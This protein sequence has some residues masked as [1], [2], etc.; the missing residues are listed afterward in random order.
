M[1]K[2]ELPSSTNNKRTYLDVLLTSREYAC[3]ARTTNTSKRAASLM[4][5]PTE[6]ATEHLENTT[7]NDNEVAA[8]RSDEQDGDG[9]EGSTSSI[10][11][12]KRVILD[13][14]RQDDSPSTL[15]LRQKY[16]TGIDGKDARI[17]QLR[18]ALE[19]EETSK[20][21]FEN[22]IA[23]EARVID[24][25][26][27]DVFF[28]PI[29]SRR[30]GMR[31][32]A[33]SE[34]RS[35][36]DEPSKFQEA[37]QAPDDENESDG[38]STS[39]AKQKRAERRALR[40]KHRREK[41]E[42]DTK[43]LD[44]VIAAANHNENKGSNFSDD[45]DD[46]SDDDDNNSSITSKSN[47][48]ASSGSSF[49]SS[50]SSSR[51]SDD[52][53]NDNCS[54]MKKK[55][56]RKKEKERERITIH[57]RCM[58]KDEK[59]RAWHKALEEERKIITSSDKERALQAQRRADRYQAKLLQRLKEKQKQKQ[60]RYLKRHR[61]AVKLTR[62]L[63]TTLKD[64]GIIA[65]KTNID[66]EKRRKH[67]QHWITK[68]RRAFDQYPQTASIFGRF[69]G[70]G[71][72]TKPKDDET[73]LAVFNVIVNF[74]DPLTTK[75]MMHHYPDGIKILRDL[76]NLCYADNDEIGDELKREFETMRIGATET[77]SNFIIRIK[78]KAN[79]ARHYL[80]LI[81]EDEVYKKVLRGI[82]RT[83]K[84]YGGLI[85][86]QEGL[87]RKGRTLRYLEKKMS[88]FDRERNLASPNK[89][90][91]AA[92]T[93]SQPSRLGRFQTLTTDSGK[94]NQFKSYCNHCGFFGHREQD[95]KGKQQGR[96]KATDEEKKQ[97]KKYCEICRKPGL[98]ETADHDKT[99]EK[100]ARHPKSILKK[101]VMIDDPDKELG[102]SA[103][104]QESPAGFFRRITSS[105]TS[106]IRTMQQVGSQAVGQM[107]RIVIS[108]FAFLTTEERAAYVSQQHRLP[109]DLPNWLFDSG[110]TAHMTPH[111]EDL[112]R[113]TPCDVII[114]LADGSEVR[115]KHAGECAIDME[116]DDGIKRKLRMGRVLYV[117]GLDRRLLSVPF[118]CQT[119]GNTMNFSADDIEMTFSGYI[120]KTFPAII[121]NRHYANAAVIRS[122]RPQDRLEHTEQKRTIRAVD[123]D[124]LHLR[125]GHRGT[126]AIL[127]ASKH[128]I[129]RDVIAVAGADPFCTSCRI[130][131]QPRASRSKEPMPIP[132]KPLDWVS[133]DIE[134]NPA[135]SKLIV[136]DYYPNIL[137]G[138]DV[139]SRKT[140]LIGLKGETSAD[141]IR[142]LKQ[143]I[144]QNGKMK[145]IRSDAGTNFLSDKVD[146]WLTEN[147]IQYDAS[148]PEGQNTNGFT[149]RHWQTIS[150]MARKM[151]VHARLSNDFVYHAL[152][153]ASAIHNALPIKNLINP[154]GVPTSPDFLF[155]GRKPKISQFRIFG[156]PVVFKKHKQ[157]KWQQQ[158][159]RGIFIGLPRRQSGWLL[160]VPQGG[161]RE[162]HVSKDVTFDES[163]VTAQ[164]CP[165]LPFQ[166]AIPLRTGRTVRTADDEA[167]WNDVEFEHTGDITS[168]YGRVDPES[169][170][171]DTSSTSADED[172]ILLE[173]AD[174]NLAETILPS[175]GEG[176]DSVPIE[177]DSKIITSASSPVDQAISN[178]DDDEA[179]YVQL[180]R[181]YGSDKT[182]QPS[183][184]DLFKNSVDK[185]MSARE[186]HTIREEVFNTVTK[187]RVDSLSGA[188]DD[189]SLYTPEPLSVSQVLKLTGA[190]R[191]R[192]LAAT[193]SEFNSVIHNKTFDLDGV[194]R[195]DEKVIP[196]KVVYKAKIRSDG[197]LEKLKARI[198]VRG[199]IHKRQSTIPE[200]PWVPL[201]SFRT[202]RRF[203]ADAVKNKR[204]L[205]Q[206]DYVSAFCQ[207]NMRGRVFVRLPDCLAEHF[208]N[209]QEYFNR[210]LLLKRG[211]YG[212][213]LAGKFWDDDMRVWLRQF[214][215]M[216]STADP[217]ILIKRTKSGWIKLMS[218]V[219]DQLYFGS[220]DYMEEEF[221]KALAKRFKIELKGKAHWFLSTR[222]TW[223]SDG[224]VIDQARYCSN[225][226][227]RYQPEGCQ[228]GRSPDRHTPLP[229]GTQMSTT[230]CAN[231][232]DGK[233]EVEKRFGKLD[234]RSCI[235]SLIYLAAGTR[236]D[237]LYAVTKLAKY[238]TNPGVRHFECLYH[239]LGYLN[240]TKNFGIRYYD[241]YEKAPV[242][243]LYKSD[244]LNID[245]T[246][247]DV[248]TTITFT[249]ASFQDQVDDGRSSGS[250]C[251]FCRGGLVD[252]G[253][254]V[255][256]PVAM[257]TGEAEYMS[258]ATGAMG[259][260][261]MRMLE[262]DLE[263]LG[264]SEYSVLSDDMQPPAVILIDN[265]A[266]KAMA[267]CER[268][269]KMTRH[270]VR[271]YHYVRQG[272]ARGDHVIKWISGENQCADIGTK[273]Q[274]KDDYE[275]CIKKMF[276]PVDLD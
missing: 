144:A 204:Q 263:N 243:K 50:T 126:N 113:I 98:H 68:L 186:I 73:N 121:H 69:D 105:I 38:D 173:A 191:D 142:G 15:N 47:E 89:R 178:D 51:S 226:L 254:F 77:G 102:L 221:E 225:L 161:C 28:D 76:I 91:F 154:V 265:T 85:M 202:L 3:M 148:P 257:S 118:F 17:R 209:A 253:C 207:G 216:P 251:I 266:A 100:S 109:K 24:T 193:K 10:D 213:T 20:A 245:H 181:E 147:G 140:T 11:Q 214:G 101:S 162:S 81:S 103:T 270:I 273:A 249:D 199:D 72:V 18:E 252:Y 276:V 167:E 236:Y 177:W 53:S 227:Q 220:C 135:P 185:A 247:G 116:D 264:A 203:V 170:T 65:L 124:L 4:S 159:R 83:H 66:A 256:C 164:Y 139:H 110:A 111:L 156:C 240:R 232:V 129:W 44:A 150:Q 194:I 218:Y 45:D 93:K 153:Y 31:K 269:S 157:G 127:T 19:A 67:F 41:K 267:E 180:E 90:E 112:E 259:A 274:K 108:E 12:S 120:T 160:Y 40:R 123:S 107:Q 56:Q 115:C 34:E 141:I 268:S 48:S 260:Q 238:C 60:K 241:D 95:C 152:Q 190:A 96:A 137:V 271:R 39:S 49:S 117:P 235:G 149:E 146:Q 242:C 14:L 35:E 131:V 188:G 250:F 272:N 1:N 136:E 138:V 184:R 206:I 9:S 231:D 97:R 182:S 145:K 70:K 6:V 133:F 166:G 195:P 22:S 224:Y 198:V 122:E 155:H 2:N 26:Q 52:G 169:S 114:T 215:F 130:A 92:H 211:L 261:H 205:K 179:L 234:Y 8:A 197:K 64:I 30:R 175:T 189:P 63:T 74:L 42:R 228:W 143:Y 125:L 58:Q 99:N 36:D 172:V 192:W 27:T 32:G 151:L 248:P 244:V 80:Q 237:I 106:A 165:D 217:S 75:S 212:L 196:L 33:D 132:P 16:Q 229:P 104:H 29:P 201:A 158:G 54:K 79:D 78:A 171:D 255:P 55:R 222:L 86:T 62:S 239:L 246:K 258:A 119:R 275:R 94:T 23:E 7:N 168:L 174:A 187:E 233:Q 128:R 176:G 208:P 88:D 223:D 61:R 37:I 183:N 25:I 82:G 87:T 84:E 59:Y 134:L 262:N 163:F 210:P 21:D 5:T 57:K 71:K 43:E 219:D 230:W 46:E 13:S 200:D